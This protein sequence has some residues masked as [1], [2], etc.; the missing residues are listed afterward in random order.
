MQLEYYQE[1]NKLV[2]QLKN[3]LKVLED[4]VLSFLVGERRNYHGVETELHLRRK[5]NKLNEEIKVKRGFIRMY[6]Y[7]IKS[8]FAD[9][10]QKA[11]MW[12]LIVSKNWKSKAVGFDL[13]EEFCSW[14]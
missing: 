13:P 5:T 8:Y 7:S 3:M 14:I 11:L 12:N 1:F 4:L 10:T 2:H 6:Y 9:S